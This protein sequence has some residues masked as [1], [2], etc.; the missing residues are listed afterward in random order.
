MSLRLPGECFFGGGYINHTRLWLT[1]RQICQF[2]YNNI[3]TNL[4]GRCPA[5]RREY[6]DEN[7]EWKS[8]SPEE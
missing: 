8:I 2:C 3:K 4:N 5:C 6:S 1:Q 7:I